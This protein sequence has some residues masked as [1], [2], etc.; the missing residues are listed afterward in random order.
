MVTLFLS[1]N[2]FAQEQQKG[3]FKDCY[4][5][6]AGELFLAP[7]FVPYNVDLTD[8]QTKQFISSLCNYMYEK[9][10]IWIDGI[11]KNEKLIHPHMAEFR[12]NYPID[13]LPDSIRQMIYGK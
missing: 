13:Q 9:T 11:I 1:P 7:I 5:T 2:L 6:T 3:S 10:G 8:P 12:D 4:A